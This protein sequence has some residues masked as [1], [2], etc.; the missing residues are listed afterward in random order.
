[1]FILKL[2]RNPAE[3]EVLGNGEQSKSYVYIDDCIDAMFFGL[4]KA[5]EKV[6]IFNIG[7]EDQIK[8]KKIAEIVAE[9]MGLNPTL[10]FTGGDRGWRGD[11][12]VML[13]SIEKLKKLGWRPKFKSEDAVR[14]A[15]RDIL[16]VA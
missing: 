3:L 4:K 13:L 6:N 16:K 15:V 1:D 7:S 10:K 2:K 9:E 12:P 14:L 11:V 5:N 8:V